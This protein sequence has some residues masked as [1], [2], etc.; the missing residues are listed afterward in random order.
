[1]TATA[2]GAWRCVAVGA[3]VSC[4]LALLVWLWVR[5]VSDAEAGHCGSPECNRYAAMLNNSSAPAA[6]P[7]EDFYQY[8]CARWTGGHGSLQVRTEPAFKWY[9]VR[10]IGV[11]TRS[12]L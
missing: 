1:M 8:V 4:G 6:D 10:G 12:F 5:L 9:A 7:C 11:L 3:A 2:A